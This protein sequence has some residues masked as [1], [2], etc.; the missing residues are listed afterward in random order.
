MFTPTRQWQD[1]VSSTLDLVKHSVSKLVVTDPLGKS[2]HSVVEFEYMCYAVAVKDHSPRY[3][4]D[5][6]NYQE[7]V[8]K[9]LEIS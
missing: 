5:F 7:M 2:D 8:V 3:L 6:G 4:Y 1:Q 9:L